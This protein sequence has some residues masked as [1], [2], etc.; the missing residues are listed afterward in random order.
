[1]HTELL[2]SIVVVGG[3]TAGWM[4]AAALATALKGRYAIRV[5][6]S[7]E[8]GIVGV[9]EATIPMIQIF[10]KIVGINE[11]EFIKATQGTFKLGI[12]FVNW[13]RLGDRYM[14]GF[15]RIGQDLWTVRFEQYWLKMRSLGRAKPLEEY[16]VTRMAS[17]ANRFLPPQA[18]VPNSPLND[19]AYAY[20][21]DA[22]LYARFLRGFAEARGVVRTEGKIVQVSQR[23]GDGHVDAVVLASGERVEGDLF[24][25]CSGFRGLLIEQT[26]QTGYED[27]THWL[28]CDR[29][30][31]VP[32]E[33]APVLTPYTRSTAHRAGWQWRI[34]LQHRTGNGHVYCSRFVSDDEAAAT[35]LS[36]LDGKPLADPRPI[37]FTTG[38]RKR[39]W[40]KNVVAIGL[41][42]GFLE[43]L[44]STS[45]HLIQSSI[46]RLIDY[47]PDR[48]FNPVDIAEYNRQSRFEYE[49][50]RD[51]IIL[52]YT[53][54][55]REDSE[56]WRACAHMSLPESLTHKIEL[57][58]AHGR[59][60]RVDNEL[61]TEFS[62]LQVFEGQNLV[63]E[64]YHPLVDLQPE[65]S[66]GEYLES[67]RNVIIKCV[68]VMP[69]H[70]AFI[71]KHCKATPPVAKPAMA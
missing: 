46:Q 12:E 26:L 17:K 51:F 13:G 69:D 60:V 27:W 34:P 18:N 52:H 23:E 66:I 9:G 7:D 63:P 19:I 33:S 11:A 29:A 40:N 25:D 28:P 20:H 16:C 45:I 70:Q 65:E 49:R 8:I 59:M 68:D 71:D 31:A 55:Q 21:F 3:G 24:I 15:G 47:F 4:T 44:E 41:A 58:K 6:E 67:V 56:F 54:N 10:N 43:P 61:F 2:K 62:W 48:G 32:C 50:I 57:Y 30:L 1:M 22:S 37:R 38:M 14:H 64:G 53:L 42:S 36:N 35:L 39:G 5:V